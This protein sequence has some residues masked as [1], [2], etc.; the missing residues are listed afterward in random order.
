MEFTA[1]KAFDAYAAIARAKG[2]LLVAASPLTRSSYH[3]GRGFREAEGGPGGQAGQ[4]VTITIAH[5]TSFRHPSEGWG[6]VV[7]AGRTRRETP[8]YAGVTG[9]KGE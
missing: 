4:S 6:I 2:F 5:P 1:P 3:A 7:S 8:A 9:C